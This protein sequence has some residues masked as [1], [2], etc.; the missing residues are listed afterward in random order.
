MPPAARLTDMHTC[1][2]VT[3]IVP[4]VGGPIIPPVAMTVLIDFLP[5]ATMTSQAVCVGPPDMVIM[6][7]TGVFINYLP[8]AR[9]GDPTVHGGVI[10]LGAM[11]VI[12]GETG[13]PSPGG[14]GAGAVMA[15]LVVAGVVGPFSA[16]ASKLS[17]PGVASDGS[18]VFDNNQYPDTPLGRQKKAEDFYSQA[19]W[20]E[21]KIASHVAGIDLSQPVEVEVLEPGTVV[22]QWVDA[23]TGQGNYFDADASPEELGICPLSVQPRVLKSFV[24]TKK[25][26]V[27]KSKAA[28][29]TIDWRPGPPVKVPG[30]AS[31]MFALPQSSGNFGNGAGA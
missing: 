2:M 17:E 7:S 10:V 1:P 23:D 8:A 16:N 21:K 26:L 19:G 4:H 27:L 28:P 30:G 29:V 9:M 25:T 24:V 12:I 13:A 3:G 20:P 11:N 5:A 18:S 31:Q 15:G 22:K 6:G 14:G